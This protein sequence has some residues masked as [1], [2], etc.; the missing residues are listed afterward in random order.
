MGGGKGG[1]VGQLLLVPE[2]KCKRCMRG[3]I[4]M[5]HCSNLIYVPKTCILSL[6]FTNA[7]YLHCTSSNL[8]D[9]LTKRGIMIINLLCLWNY[10]LVIFKPRAVK[11]KQNDCLSTHSCC[12]C[13]DFILCF[14]HKVYMRLN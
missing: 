7:C 10:L 3:S 11:T 5:F 9:H 4:F 1:V 12:A 13:H 8:R 2:I 14:N 6:N